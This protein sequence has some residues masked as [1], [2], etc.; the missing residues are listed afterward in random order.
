MG[1]Y[2]FNLEELFTSIDR[3]DTGSAAEPDADVADNADM[4]Y[5]V[6][7]GEEL[8]H[9]GF[10]DAQAEEILLGMEQHLPVQCYARV[11]YN[12]KQMRELRKGL[13]DHLDISMYNNEFYSA[14][15]MR[16]IRKG[17]QEHIPVES[18]ANL[19]YT[20][21]DMEQKRRRLLSDAYWENSAGYGQELTDDVSGIRIRISDDCMQAFL[22]LP[23]GQTF[24][25]HGLEHVLK[26]NDITCGI[27]KKQ[28]A[29]AAEGVFGT[30]EFLAAAGRKAQNGEDGR[31][32]FFFDLK[33]SKKPQIQADGTV[34]YAQIISADQTK[35]GDLLAKYHPAQPGTDGKTVTGI[36]VLGKMGEE[37]DALHGHGIICDADKTLYRADTVGYVAF[38]EEKS[39]L[40]VWNIYVVDGDVNRYNGNITYDGIIHIRGT[41]SDMARIEATGNVMV[42]GYV[43]S[44]SIKAGGNIILNRGMNGCGKGTLEAGGKVTG[45]FF[46]S[47]KIYAAGDVEGN[48]FLNCQ[49][50]TDGSLLART[51]KSKIVGGSIKAGYAVETYAVSS[52]GKPVAAIEVGNPVWL[53]ERM[54]RIEEKLE[55]TKEELRHL[56]EGKEKVSG[57]LGGE[58]AKQNTLFHKICMA[59]CVKEEELELLHNEIQRCEQV[60]K[61]A[62]RAYIRVLNSIQAGV[63][64]SVCGKI[65]KVERDLTGSITF[66]TERA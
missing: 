50:E 61:R 58:N 43:E 24:S 60:K 7:S 34:D 48:Y 37:Q 44:A 17:L 2:Q 20:A 65:K 9:M 39:S 30:R 23:A 13:Q 26:R 8:E 42:D 51:A 11:C 49:V 14:E 38:D 57:M 12:W 5:V 66:R 21:R 22:K 10:G 18:Y 31:Y 40:N 35:P 62:K 41:V 4:E 52:F 16:Q 46:E 3:M 15:Q 27:L 33:L 25:V 45:K 63:T 64:L 53:A 19:V 47:V 28:L 59:V 1:K 56:T 32:E 55:K 54:H 36:P 6:Y 29:K